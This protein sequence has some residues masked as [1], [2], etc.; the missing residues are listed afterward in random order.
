M[1]QSVWDDEF[2][3]SDPDAEENEDEGDYDFKEYFDDQSQMLKVPSSKN[4]KH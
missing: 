1:R 3:M 2:E 4:F